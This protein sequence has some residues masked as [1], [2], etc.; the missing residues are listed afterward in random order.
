FMHRVEQNNHAKIHAG[1][2]ELVGS[3]YTYSSS[4]DIGEGW[5]SVDMGRNATSTVNFT[6]LKPYTGAGAPSPT[7]SVYAAGNAVNPRHFLVR[8]NGDSV[9]GLR[10]DYYDYAKAQTTVPI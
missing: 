2:A 3:S 4:Y 10:M 8:L 6:N 9:M 1:R 7:L 5:T